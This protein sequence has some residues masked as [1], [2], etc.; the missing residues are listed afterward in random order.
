MNESELFNL[1]KLTYLKDLEKSEIQFSKW[2]CFSPKYNLRIELKCRNKHYNQLMLEYSK[3]NFLLTTYKEKNEI[4]LYINST[5]NGIYSFDLRN[6][7][8]QWITDSR[9]PKTTEFFEID[10][11]EKTYT[12]IDIEESIKIL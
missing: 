4:P 10:K 9:M 3:Y 7:K 12:L 2:D 5:P 11:V 1:L 8:P 6:I